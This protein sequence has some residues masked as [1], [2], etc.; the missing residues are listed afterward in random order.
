LSAFS[1][2]ES[3][4]L[5]RIFKPQFV[6]A[7]NQLPKANGF[8]ASYMTIPKP[9]SV[10]FFTHDDLDAAAPLHPVFIVH[11]GGHTGYTQG[12][13]LF[14][15]S[16]NGSN[17]YASY[18]EHLKGSLEPGKLADLVVLGNDPE[19]TAPDKIIDIPIERVMVGGSWVYEA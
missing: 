1:S 4:T 5:S 3:V 9:S 14:C 8:K 12:L 6:N 19:T 10:V 15:D 18:E 11:R 2:G 13:T 17:A 7:P 16:T